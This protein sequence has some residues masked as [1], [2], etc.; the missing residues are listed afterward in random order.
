M[1]ITSV[2]IYLQLLDLLTT[3]VGFK[4]GAREASPF[5]RMLMHAGPATGVMVSKVLSLGLG[6]LCLYYKK[7]HLI[8]WI[9]YW[10]GGL[11][12]WNLMVLLASPTPLVR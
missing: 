5:I 3:L 12:V 6:A 7:N 1:A 2:F 4:L 9:S 10:Y 11:I 8:R